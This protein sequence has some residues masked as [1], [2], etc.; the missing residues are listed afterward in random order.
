VAD[1]SPAAAPAGG[2]PALE[3]FQAA[4]ERY[5]DMMARAQQAFESLERLRDSALAQG[6]PESALAMPG[7]PGEGGGSAEQATPSKLTDAHRQLLMNARQ[8]AARGQLDTPPLQD[9]QVQAMRAA[10]CKLLEPCIERCLDGLRDERG[11]LAMTNARVLGLIGAPDAFAAL[12]EC[13]QEQFLNE[14]VFEALGLLG[15]ARAVQLFENIYGQDRF[16][17][18]R[19]FIVHA[20]ARI[21]GQESGLFLARTLDD[22]D[23][24]IRN[25]TVNHIAACKRVELAPQVLDRLGTAGDNVDVAIAKALVALTP[26]DSKVADKLQERLMGSDAESRL[27]KALVTALGRTGSA[28]A[29]QAL[30]P[31]TKSRDARLKRIAIDAVCDLNIDVESKMKYITPSLREVGARG[32][33]PPKVRAQSAVKAAEL[34]SDAGAAALL[35]MVQSN[36]PENRNWACWGMGEIRHPQALGYLGKGVQD[37]D[38]GVRLAAIK[39]LGA[40]ADPKGA[41]HLVRA[42]KD[43]SD[44]LRAAACKALALLGPSSHPH[45]KELT[46]SEFRPSVLAPAVRA[47]GT[48]DPQPPSSYPLLAPFLTNDEAQVRLA[49]TESACRMVHEEALGLL[50][51]RLEDTE[52]KVSRAAA[53]GLWC[54]GEFRLVPRVLDLQE[55]EDDEVRLG[56]ALVLQ[57]LAEI[58]KDL[59]ETPKAGRLVAALHAVAG[60]GV[61]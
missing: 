34:G 9:A 52:H 21:P 49:A 54:Y 7:G 15:D 61:A 42:L 10:A 38:L 5:Q 60:G 2:H 16:A 31:F 29:L 27:G 30:Q 14:S 44:E 32:E 50:L 35:E 24:S 3:N 4:R 20:V 40:L 18:W 36:N 23:P 1:A 11:E 58:Q 56:A 17:N 41:N 33:T 6:V 25:A 28:D 8:L 59:A 12:S 45:L 26:G 39:A 57:E 55:N 47:L 51:D 37:Q 19:Q 53:R 48:T 46:E 13:I 43:P 22:P